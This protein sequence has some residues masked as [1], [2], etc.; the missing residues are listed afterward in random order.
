VGFT[1]LKVTKVMKNFLLRRPAQR[2]PHE[3]YPSLPQGV[4]HLCWVLGEGKAESVRRRPTTMVK[5]ANFPNFP[6]FPKSRE[7]GMFA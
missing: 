2:V 1:V 5:V 6:N 4:E 7:R 3:R